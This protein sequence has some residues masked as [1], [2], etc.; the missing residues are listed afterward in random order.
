MSDAPHAEGPAVSR[1]VDWAFDIYRDRVWESGDGLIRDTPRLEALVAATPVGDRQ[2]ISDPSAA[3][4]EVAGLLHD[5]L[6]ERK[7]VPG[8]AAAAWALA[9]TCL[10][11]QGVA[12]TADDE[13]AYDLIMA[14]REGRV[15][16]ARAAARLSMRPVAEAGGHGESSRPARPPAVR[17]ATAPDARK[18]F[19][20]RTWSRRRKPRA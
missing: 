7:S 13:V 9:E 4:L 14:I 16:K 17:A 19:P 15:T 20:A 5:L 3:R 6:V 12:V 10:L 11:L 18:R 1:L 8:N 2:S